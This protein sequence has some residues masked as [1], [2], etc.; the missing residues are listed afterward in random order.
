MQPHAILP[1]GTEMKTTIALTLLLAIM[2][3]S[4]EEMPKIPIVAPEKIAVAAEASGTEKI[5]EVYAKVASDAAAHYRITKRSG[6]VMGACAEATLVSATFL[7]AKDEA[8]HK[9]WEIT[10]KADCKAAGARNQH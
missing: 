7:L 10:E 2:G 6:M 9:A 5:E 3:C 4:K 8:N 1:Q